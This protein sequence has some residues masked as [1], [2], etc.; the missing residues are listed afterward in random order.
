MLEKIQ[1]D[2]DREPLFKRKGEFRFS[3]R[4]WTPDNG[5]ILKETVLPEA[6][7][8]SLSDRP[9]SNEVTLNAVLFE[10]WVEKTLAVK[11]GGVELDT[12][13]P[14]DRLAAVHR[15]VQRRAH[16]VVWQLCSDRRRRRSCR[17]WG[18]G[19]SGSGSSR[20]DGAPDATAEP[21][22]RTKV[23]WRVIAC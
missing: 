5:G 22:R 20:P 7:H 14:D 6:G 17:I 16:D 12:F 11:I 23:S 8:F 9:G 21:R 18:A 2:D 15:C 10:D 13:D 4:V 19:S 1:I 3:S